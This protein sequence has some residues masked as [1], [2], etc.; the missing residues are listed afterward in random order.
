MT[1]ILRLG[2]D[3]AGCAPIDEQDVIGGTNIGLVFTDGDTLADA[4]TLQPA[5]TSLASI[6]S[7]AICSGF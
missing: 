6:W 4:W 3:D 2:L 7:R 1:P 5:S